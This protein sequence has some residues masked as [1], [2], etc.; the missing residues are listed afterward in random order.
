VTRPRVFLTRELPPE[1]MARL[2]EQT[3]LSVN[4]E[5]RALSRAALLEGVR[6]HDGLLC[7]RHRP[8]RRRACWTLR[9]ACAAVANYAVGFDNVDVD[10]ATRRGVPVT[11]TP[12]VL[13]AATADMAFALLL[14]VARRLVEGHD[15]V[16]SRTLARA[17]AR[18][19]CSVPR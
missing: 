19:S 1:P 10:A 16:R 14:A 3:E 2:R 12:D 9:R 11:N 8:R 6:G 15:L 4:P 13:T 7:L 5:N 17:G 18:C